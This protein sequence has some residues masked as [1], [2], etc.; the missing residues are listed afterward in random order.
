[1]TVP[2]PPG[3]AFVLHEA[4]VDSIHAAYASGELSC[5]ALVQA[6]F[7]RMAGYDRCDPIAGFGAG[8]RPAS[9]AA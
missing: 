6:Y 5:T 8:R 9:D 7:E 1:M 2:V 3:Q 4:T